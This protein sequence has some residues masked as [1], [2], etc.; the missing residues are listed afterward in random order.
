MKERNHEVPQAEVPRA[1]VLLEAPLAKP[2]TV[3]TFTPFDQCTICFAVDVSGSTE[4][5]VLEE[6]KA[7]IEIIAEDLPTTTKQRCSIIPWDDD[8]DRYQASG[9]EGLQQLTS[10]GGTDPVVLLKNQVHRNF[11]QES[12]VWFLLTDGEMDLHA[13]NEFTGAI[14]THGLHSKACVLV[15]YGYRPSIPIHCNIPV[16]FRYS[17]YRQIVYFYSTILRHMNCCFC[18]PRAAS[19]Y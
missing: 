10:Y 9:L 16:G 17:G 11:L 8:V 19:I 15:I 18:K 1:K 13:V 3:D 12:K 2:I 5:V 7:A 14:E 4:G 6:E